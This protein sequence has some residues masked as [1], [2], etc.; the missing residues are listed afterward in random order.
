MK[1]EVCDPKHLLM[2]FPLPSGDCKRLRLDDCD[3]GMFGMDILLCA[4][5]AGL[6]LPPPQVVTAS[7]GGGTLINVPVTERLS[8]R[9]L[10]ADTRVQAA[11]V[12]AAL[13]S[14]D[15]A[16]SAVDDPYGVVL[17][18]AAQV[19]ASAL[20]SIDLAGKS[21]VELG[22]G[23]GLVSLTAAACGATSVLA[24]DYRVEPL[25]ASA[26]LDPP[27]S[28]LVVPCSS[29]FSGFFSALLACSPRGRR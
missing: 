11:L 27:A 12:D 14:D 1:N 5:V 24:T 2:I 16:G 23:T 7:R 26:R 9:L 15:S 25:G 8:L 3:A 29:H 28:S 18:P 19:V 22:C 13:A 20:A 6:Y 17:W 4:C 10:E 21:V